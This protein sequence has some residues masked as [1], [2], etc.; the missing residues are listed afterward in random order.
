[1]LRTAECTPQR[2]ARFRF[3]PSQID[4]T[5]A[6]INL[7]FVVYTE[8][9]HLP[10]SYSELSKSTPKA[11]R[12]RKERHNQ[13]HVMVFSNSLNPREGPMLIFDYADSRR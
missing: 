8:T 12:R 5:L 3:K 1:M 4:Q 6:Y 10:P 13:K 7:I 2:L 9:L 11:Y